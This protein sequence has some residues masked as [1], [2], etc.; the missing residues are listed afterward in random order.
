M[1]SDE[2]LRAKTERF[3]FADPPIDPVEL[4]TI[5]TETMLREN[6]A[7]L[8]ANQVGFPYSVFVI[9]SD[10]IIA[11]FNPRVV[12][13]LGEE[14]YLDEGCLSWPNLIVKIKRPEG[15]RLRFTMPNG[16]TIT[17]E[18]HGLTARVVLHELDHLAGEVFYEKATRYHREL[19][20][21]RMKKR[22]R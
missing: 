13:Y 10:P 20:F 18:F 2:Y 21:K 4:A 15:V 3:D 8:A 17:R 6:G 14:V 11:A 19:A 9:K 5:L 16:E 1:L 7:G 12:D 22:K